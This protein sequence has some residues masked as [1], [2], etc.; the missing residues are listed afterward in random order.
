MTDKP[1]INPESEI[2]ELSEQITKKFNEV[3]NWHDQTTMAFLSQT[4]KM[5]NTGFLC[6]ESPELKKKDISYAGKNAGTL[7]SDFLIAGRN[8]SRMMKDAII[9]LA[10]ADSA[11]ELP[12]QPALQLVEATIDN[13]VNSIYDPSRLGLGEETKN[14]ANL[15]FFLAT[16]RPYILGFCK[17]AQETSE[18]IKERA[19]II[20]DTREKVIEVIV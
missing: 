3:K 18:L 9:A 10:S 13:V 5:A 19:R 7:Q 16:M 20:R 17:S 14:V 11:Y 2:V 12:N 4:Q 8:L 15:E 6:G 1:S